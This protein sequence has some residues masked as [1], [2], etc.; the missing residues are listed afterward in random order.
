MERTTRYSKKRAAILAAVARVNHH[1][2]RIR[3]LRRKG[4]NAGRTQARVEDGGQAR[5]TA[6]DQQAPQKKSFMNQDDHRQH[7]HGAYV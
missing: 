5:H 4:R 1:G 3:T 7:P 6:E 2:H